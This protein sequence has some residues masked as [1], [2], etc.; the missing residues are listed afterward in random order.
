MK[1][2]GEQYEVPLLGLRTRDNYGVLQFGAAIA[3]FCRRPEGLGPLPINNP[4]Q[5]WGNAQ[6][7]DFGK[8]KSLPELPTDEKGSFVDLVRW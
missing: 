1:T 5:V 8:F 6:I 7:I 3:F 2:I 4:G